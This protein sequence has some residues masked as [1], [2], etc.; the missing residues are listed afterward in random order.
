MKQLITC[1]LSL[2]LATSFAQVGQQFPKIDGLDLND[3]SISLPQ[4]NGKYSIIAIAYLREAEPE[5]KKWLN[6]LYNEFVN[7]DKGKSD[8]DMTEAYDI[9]FYFVPM[10]SGLKIFKNEY[11]N[12][13]DK[14]FWPYIVDTEKYDIKGMQKLLGVTNPK[15]P[16]F[17]V[18]D[19]SGK[20]VNVQ[21]GSFNEQ[22][23]EKMAEAIQ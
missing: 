8:F 12:N 18:I 5:M 3:E 11:K 21:S 17:Y 23:M 10:I 7:K 19:K 6:P 2:V 13:T 16:Y 22:K 4:S 15:V 20:I 1:L 14:A 9:N